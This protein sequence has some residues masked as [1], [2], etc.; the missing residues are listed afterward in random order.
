MTDRTVLYLR[1]SKDDQTSDNQL[2]QLEELAVR[3]GWTIAGIYQ[4]DAIS[5][6]K[7]RDE[8]PDLDRLLKDAARRRFDRLLCWSV[9]RMGRSAGNVMMN[10]AE[11]NNLGI[12]QFYHLQGMDTSNAYGKAMVGMA[13]VFA[14]LELS[15]IKERIHAGLDRARAEGKKLGRKPL[16]A[17][18]IDLV[19]ALWNDPK[20]QRSMREVAE[21]AGVSKGSVHKILHAAGAASL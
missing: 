15:I 4:D 1:V 6:E 7:E 13:A 3:R 19:I 14:E 2:L 10:I 17:Q 18:Q 20:K 9:D 5:G 21:E 8:R 12:E 11:L 16:T